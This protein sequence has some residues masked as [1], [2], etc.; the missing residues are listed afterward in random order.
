MAL[1]R[2]GDTEKSLQGSESNEGQYRAARHTGE[3]LEVW[4]KKNIFHRQVQGLSED[5]EREKDYSRTSVQHV[6]EAEISQLK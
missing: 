4:I 1:Q 6:P 5:S 2:P 3:S